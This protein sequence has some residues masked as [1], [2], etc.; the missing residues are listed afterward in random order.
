MNCRGSRINNFI[1]GVGF[2]GNATKSQRG[3][4]FNCTFHR[5]LFALQNAWEMPKM[6]PLKA[7]EKLDDNTKKN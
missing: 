2:S 5:D 4:G 3:E 1:R 7:V 6:K